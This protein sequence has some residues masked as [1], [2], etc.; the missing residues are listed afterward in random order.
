MG[1]A[2]ATMK[3]Q[4]AQELLDE[5]RRSVLLQSRRGAMIGVSPI[6]SGGATSTGM[7]VLARRIFQFG[8]QV[9]PARNKKG[10]EVG[11]Q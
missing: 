6:N 5:T 9:F 11:R 4:N 1:A 8:S 2:L 7:Q 10:N 3:T